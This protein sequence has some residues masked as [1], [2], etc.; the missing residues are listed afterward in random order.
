MSLPVHRFTV[1]SVARPA[2]RTHCRRCGTD[3][4]FVCAEQFRANGNGKLVDI[5]L[6][7]RC[8]ECDSTRNVTV[9]E[10]TAVHRIDRCLLEAAYDNDPSVARRCARDRALLRRAGV[11]VDGGDEWAVAEGPP[12]SRPP[13]RFVL[14]FD[15][16]LLV[17]LDA[18]AA[19]VLGVPRSAVRG[20][21]TVEGRSAR[22]DGLRLW[23]TV[24]VAHRG[25]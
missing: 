20:R 22:L 23:S 8:A 9:V 1:V 15:E 10:R 17:R 12:P 5:W 2:I 16:P 18:V 13:D 21:L 3:R 11:A 7:Y 4:R 24:A 6:L 14:Q 25:E 19:G